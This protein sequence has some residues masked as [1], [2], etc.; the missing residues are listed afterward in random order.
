MSFRKLGLTHERRIIAEVESSANV[1]GGATDIIARFISSWD[2]TLKT[3]ARGISSRCKL[4]R[5]GIVESGSFFSSEEQRSNVKG[6]SESADERE[7]NEEKGNNED[8]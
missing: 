8:T 5:F 3:E 4:S 7:D 1:I 6:R 2:I